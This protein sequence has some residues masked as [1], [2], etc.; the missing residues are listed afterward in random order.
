MSIQSEF[1][2]FNNKIRLDYGTNSELAE[3]RD[4][5]LGILE[6]D[7]D[8]FSRIERASD[9]DVVRNLCA[10]GLPLGGLW[11]SDYLEGKRT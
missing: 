1:K 10:E 5:L 8:G 11:Y 7:E 2:K 4:I 6:K 9:N 3:K